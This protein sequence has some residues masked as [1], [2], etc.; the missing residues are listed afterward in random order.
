MDINLIV[1]LS[2]FCFGLV[3]T[4]F[5]ICYGKKQIVRKYDLL[6]KYFITL[7][8]IF[9]GVFASFYVTD[10]SATKQN[11]ERALDLLDKSYNEFIG[12]GAPSYYTY[13]VNFESY[14]DKINVK[15]YHVRYMQNRRYFPYSVKQLVED[16]SIKEH[17][18]VE[19]VDQI[20]IELNNIKHLIFVL[21]KS[22]HMLSND[23]IL[24]KL[25][26]IVFASTWIGRQMEW[27]AQYI[28]GR[29]SIDSLQSNIKGK[30]NIIRNNLKSE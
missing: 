1:L 26:M 30:I 20:N 18:S 15:N 10:Y 8:G 22:D 28:R 5:K 17:L 21:E 14:V 9:I 7:I 6:L 4:L 24:A 12:K 3:L 19:T 11:K 13:L 23:E 27:E 29:I 25:E 16:I 2:V